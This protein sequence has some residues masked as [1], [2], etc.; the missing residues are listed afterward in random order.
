GGRPG[1]DATEGAEAPSV[2]ASGKTTGRL[3]WGGPAPTRRGGGA[4]VWIP[5]GSPD[6]NDVAASAAAH[7]QGPVLIMHRVD[8]LLSLVPE[9]VPRRAVSAGGNSRPNRDRRP[10]AGR[11]PR[12]RAGS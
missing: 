3:A 8:H 10:R 11:P 2:R 5:P 9:L 7:L 1:R 6:V 4:A 12:S